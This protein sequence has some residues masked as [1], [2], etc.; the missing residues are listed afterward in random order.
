MAT[1]LPVPVGGQESPKCRVGV[2]MLQEFVTTLSGK[3]GAALDAH[4]AP[5]ADSLW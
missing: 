4:L 2:S 3:A 5:V 1:P